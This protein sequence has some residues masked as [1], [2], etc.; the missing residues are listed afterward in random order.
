MLGENAALN[1]ILINVLNFYDI[2]NPNLIAL[3]K[4]II[5]KYPLAIGN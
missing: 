1:D 3:F 5:N 2:V 4:F